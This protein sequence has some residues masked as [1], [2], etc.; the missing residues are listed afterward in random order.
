MVMQ[1]VSTSEFKAKCL[2]ITMLVV[3][4]ML[5]AVFAEANRELTGT[6]RPWKKITR[7]K[8]IVSVA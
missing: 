8:I 3:D 5:T 2:G 1:D 4:M 7:E 6:P